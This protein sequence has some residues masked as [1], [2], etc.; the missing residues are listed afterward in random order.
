MGERRIQTLES[1][2]D[3]EAEALQI[4]ERGAAIRMQD[5]E[6]IAEPPEKPRGA[7]SDEDE[8]EVSEK[9]RF[10]SMEEVLELEDEAFRIG[11]DKDWI[12]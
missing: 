6:T 5:P 2:L 11:F 8:E 12:E 3:V 7:D 10:L 1:G 4:I 9:P